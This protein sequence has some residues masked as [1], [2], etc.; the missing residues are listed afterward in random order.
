MLCI[1]DFLLAS[2]FLVG[3][4]LYLDGD[5]RGYFY[6]GCFAVSMLTIV[7]CAVSWSVHAIETCDRSALNQKMHPSAVLDS[8]CVCVV[9]KVGAFPL[10]F[11]I[12]TIRADCLVQCFNSSDIA[13]RDS[14]SDDDLC[15]VCLCP[16][17]ADPQPK[18]W[19]ATGRPTIY[20]AVYAGH[21][22]HCST[23][24]HNLETIAP[25]Q[26]A[27]HS[28]LVQVLVYLLAWWAVYLASCAH[29]LLLCL[30]LY[31]VVPVVGVVVPIAAV[32][33]VYDTFSDAKTQSCR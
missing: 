32:G 13:V 8:H 33:T 5:G 7:S 6:A 29:N 12:P 24:A 18:H 10:A 14:C 15:N 19:S 23:C 16:C 25:Q 26:V 17:E 3:G 4:V 22:V 31:R 28:C 9:L 30:H 2:L 20:M 27:E 21:A 11:Y 1:A